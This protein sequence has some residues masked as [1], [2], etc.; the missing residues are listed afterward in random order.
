MGR[1]AAK[2]GSAPQGQ[3]RPHEDVEGASLEKPVKRKR[4]ANDL[5]MVELYNDLS[6]ESED[7]RLEAAKQLILKFSPENSP[8]APNVLNA[9]NRLIQGLCT[10]RK[11]ARFG[12][13]VTLT[14]LLRLIF[15]PSGASIEGLDLDVVALL[16][17]V[18]KQTKTEGNVSGLE[19][20]NH[21]IGKL[22]AYKAILQSSILIE[23]KLATNSWN[24]LLDLIYGMARDTP[25]L[26][27]ECA[28]V[29]VQTIETLPNEAKLEPCVQ[30][31]SERLV[32]FKLADTP[33]GIAIWLALQEQHASSLPTN[34]WHDNDPLSMKNRPKLAKVLKGDLQSSL[35]SNEPDAV[36]SAATN[37]N[38]Q[39][40]W[41]T[42]LSKVLQLDSESKAARTD[43]SKS[44]FGQLWL[45]IVDAQLFGSSSSHERKSWGFKLFAQL[46]IQIPDWALSALFSPNFMR[47]LRNQTSKDDSKLPNLHCPL[48]VELT[49]KNGTA[50]F[51]HSSKAETLEK[52][53]LAADDHGLRKIVR[54][55]HSQLIRPETTEQN[56][57]DHR[58]QT[59]ADLLLN[60]VK[61]YTRYDE[62]VAEFT[63]KDNWLRNTLDLL[64]EH[65]YFTPSQ[66]AKA[67]KVP[68]PA[69]SDSSRAI[70]QER[71]SSCLTRLRPVAAG[72][73]TSFG[74]IVVDMVR[75]KASSQSFEPIFKADESVQETLEK[76]YE[77]FDIVKTTGST[78]GKASVFQGLAL[79]YAFTFI[80]I[81]NG[82]T[83]AIMLLHD[84]DASYKAISSPKK[85]ASSEGQDGF[86][87][88][89]LSF[90]GNTRTLF[91]KIATEAFTAFASE[92]S[93][94]GLRSMTDILDTEETLE[95]QKQL[96][97]QA[98]EEAEEAESD[99]DEDMEDA[100]DVEMVS[101]DAEE[102]AGS[103][104]DDSDDSDD[105][106]E[107]EDED[108][109][110]ELTQFN[111]KLALT[112]QT[113]GLA[114][115]DEEDSDDSD[116]DD[117]QM[118]ALDPH[119]S[120]IFKQRSQITGKKQ[121]DE[122]KQNMIRFKSRVLD[123]LAVFLD[124]QFSNPLS[125]EVL[126]PVLRLTRASANKQFSDR[127]AKLLQSIFAKSN[128]PLPQLDDAEPAWEILRAVHEEAKQGGG[129]I[130]HGGA[131]SAASLHIVRTLVNA[132]PD[133]YAKVVDVYAESQKNWFMDTKSEVR[134]SMFSQFLNWS[135]RFRSAIKAEAE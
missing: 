78:D 68:S 110:D 15:A 104:S 80:Q 43:A 7:I 98:D 113:S 37:A 30:A 55:L 20:R 121:R 83:D 24:E 28:L 101:G 32:S 106:S 128:T 91:H 122:A 118:M 3:K 67:R 90:L 53:A 6:A 5:S 119:L 39:F 126:L 52:I 97:S 82:D 48:V 47:T 123:L 108:D 42:L 58:R 130:A 57:A 36:K 35:S 18:E 86:I 102:D 23:P 116:M 87:E 14:E 51:E 79:L 89:L 16:K 127:S 120:N 10:H 135:S 85:G 131:C 72:T 100:S 77:T 21:L 63:E 59:I 61:H 62:L 117:D 92:I 75:S 76:A 41:N 93:L 64:V 105:D 38:P 29:L 109:D 111:N 8:S 9:L 134:D 103:D 107:D 132:D 33:E 17:K 1:K 54:H 125:L 73:Q 94:E 71:L 49:S 11:A 81:F 99:D 4:Q 13:C 88:I 26:R 45:S 46:V 34:V 96:F 56:V 27:E 114:A 25:W 22:F 66:S 31:L 50:D 133:N 112:L 74:V 2:S 69:I 129:S 19:R 44:Q 65:A 12:F 40:A 115:N 124:K 70:F 60:I 95:G 84:L